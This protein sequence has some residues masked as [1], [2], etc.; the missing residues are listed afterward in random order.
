MKAISIRQPWVWAFMEAGKPVENRSWCTSYRGP[1]LLH[2]SKTFDMPGKR[3][4]EKHMG[5]KVPGNLPRGGI[6]ARGR[7]VNCV[8]YMDSP[9]F[10]GPFGLVITEVEPV[11]FYNCVGRL[12]LFDAPD[13]GAL[14]L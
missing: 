14:E 9:W 7:L 8:E 1:I 11:Q 10:F 3:W 13:Q 5:I 12:R 4:I 6:V 2:A